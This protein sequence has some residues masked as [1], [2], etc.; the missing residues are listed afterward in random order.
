ML[1][2]LSR[3]SRRLWSSLPVSQ[4]S[5]KRIE[6]TLMR[7]GG[8]RE[9][10]QIIWVQSHTFL[11]QRRTLWEFGLQY[12]CQQLLP[13][14]SIPGF[15]GAC[16]WSRAPNFLNAGRLHIQHLGRILFHHKIQ[17]WLC[18]LAKGSATTANFLWKAATCVAFQ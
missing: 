14:Q 15:W 2:P 3:L 11:M 10:S 13:S 4:E 6:K 7:Y 9:I 12:N 16:S 5:S 8:R 18:L 1:M 17:E